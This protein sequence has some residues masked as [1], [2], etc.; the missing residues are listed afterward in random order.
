MTGKGLNQRSRPHH[1]SPSLLAPLSQRSNQCAETTILLYL[2]IFRLLFLLPPIIIS[3][4]I[5]SCL[6]FLCTNLISQTKPQGCHLSPSSRAR[7]WRVTLLGF[8]CR[9]PKMLS[10]WVEA[11]GTPPQHRYLPNP[12][13]PQWPQ[14]PNNHPL[15]HPWYPS[16]SLGTKAKE[17]TLQ[18]L[19]V[20]HHHRKGSS[21]PQCRVLPRGMHP[22]PLWL[23]LDLGDMCL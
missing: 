3:S 14:T 22:P 13:P 1:P 15:S 5:T 12:C 18:P 17:R 10:R 9:S 7:P 16:P 23:T 6:I 11:M 4:Q 8:T 21:H 19:S 20:E 2:F